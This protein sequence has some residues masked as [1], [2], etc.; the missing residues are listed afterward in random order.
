MSGNISSLI[1]LPIRSLLEFFDEAPEYG[2]GHATA[3]TAVLGEELGA[4]LLVDYFRGKNV[5]A[6]VLGLPCTQGTTSGKRLDRWIKV[7][8][9]RQTTYFQVEIKN[10]SATAIGGRRIAINA[11]NSQLREHKI[12]RWSKEWNGQGFI[13][14]AVAKVLTPMKPPVIGANVEPLACFW[15]AMHPTGKTDALFSIP[16]HANKF[17]RV[18]I[19]SMSAYLRNLFKAGQE[20]V[21]IDAPA[22]KARLS[23]LNKLL[24]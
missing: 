1:R 12:E 8:K 24:N 14:E 23:L 3:I 11:S 7:T 20:F 2:K 6:E 17:P 13:K 9:G 21:E 5:N 16:T 18:W 19:F 22:A 4:G 15:D 10:W